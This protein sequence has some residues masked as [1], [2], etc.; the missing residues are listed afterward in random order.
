MWTR[1]IPPLR[2]MDTFLFPRQVLPGPADYQ[3]TSPGRERSGPAF[4]MLGRPDD[5]PDDVP[6]PGEYNIPDSWRTGAAY[7]ISGRPAPPAPA[8]S[9]GPGAY[10]RPAAP[11]G[12]AYS[13]GGRALDAPPGDAPGPTDYGGADDA[14]LRAAAPAYTIAGRPAARERHEDADLPGPGAYDG[15][16][17]PR[18]GSPSAPAYSLGAR[19][20]PRLAGTSPGPAD[21]LLPAAPYAGP[22]VT[23]GALPPGARGGGGGGGDVDGSP[24]PAAYDSMLARPHVGADGP[25]FTMGALP[26]PERAP[27][28]AAPGDYFVERDAWRE[29]PAYSIAARLR[30]RSPEDSPGPGEYAPPGGERGP[31]YTMRGRA[32]DGQ[33]D[34]APG[35]G[36]YECDGGVNG[37]AFSLGAKL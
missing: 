30:I 32:E 35:P 18:P 34:D 24:G 29:G 19:P 9:P 16:A 37:P 17:R 4:S 22:A 10:H 20:A 11:R 36:D 23:M 2:R 8:D 14:V 25:A 31:A 7:T 28:G 3:R 33:A 21:Y 6:A 15:S 12:S 1:V 13:L 26:P 27:D 5:P